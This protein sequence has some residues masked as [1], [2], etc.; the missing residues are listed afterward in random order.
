MKKIILIIAFGLLSLEIQAQEL[1]SKWSFDQFQ[2]AYVH[3]DIAAKTDRLIGFVD[4]LA[5]KKL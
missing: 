4:P 3:E 2:E 5:P 1:I